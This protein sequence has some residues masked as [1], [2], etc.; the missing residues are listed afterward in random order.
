MIWEVMIAGF[1]LGLVSSLHC[2]GM[3]GPI[4]LSIPVRHLSPINRN[5]ALLVYNFGRTVSYAVLGLIFGFFGQAISL[6]GFQQSLSILL[7]IFIL[8]TVFIH[9]S[10]RTL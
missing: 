10:K 7:G 4:A 9:Y 8:F 1:L 5:L 6:A 3:C 2:I